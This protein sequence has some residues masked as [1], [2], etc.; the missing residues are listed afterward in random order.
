MSGRKKRFY[1]SNA[2]HAGCRSSPVGSTNVLRFGD[3]HPADMA[4]YFR[5]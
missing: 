1:D 2:A 4:S 5:E 3:L